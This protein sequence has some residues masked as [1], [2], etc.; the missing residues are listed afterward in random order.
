MKHFVSENIYLNISD[1]DIFKS[2]K[3]EMIYNVF[4]YTLYILNRFHYSI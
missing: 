4:V 1:L 3:V 2:E